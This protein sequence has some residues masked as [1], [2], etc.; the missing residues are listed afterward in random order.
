MGHRRERL[1]RDARLAPPVQP[2]RSGA[3]HVLGLGLPPEILQVDHHDPRGAL[4]QEG[5]AG[6]G[7][8][9]RV[10]LAFGEPASGAQERDER[11]PQAP[12]LLLLPARAPPVEPAQVDAILNVEPS[13]EGGEGRHVVGVEARE[14]VVRDVAEGALRMGLQRVLDHVGAVDPAA[15]HLGPNLLG[16]GPEVLADDE[17]PVTVGEQREE[18]VEL[19]RRIAY[20]DAVARLEAAGH[21]EEAV[22]RH[23]VVDP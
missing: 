19:L 6:R 23:H 12:A 18:G 21:P 1:E 17:G 5:D 8:G 20:I 7:H 2:L 4:A 11:L 9:L 22:E 15:R 14:R 13:P 10:V 16:H 3:G